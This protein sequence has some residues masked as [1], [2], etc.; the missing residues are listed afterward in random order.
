MIAIRDAGITG[1]DAVM[2]AVILI[3]VLSVANSSLFGSSRTLAA[4]ASQGQAPKILAYVDRTGRPIVAIGVASASG[5]LA[6]LSVSEVRGEAFKWLLA[7]SGLSSIFTWASICL[8]HVRFR[9]AWLAQNHTLDE[10]VY[11]SPTG[12][13][14]SWIGFLALIVVLV[15]QLW[16]ALDPVGT[17]AADAREAVENFF[18]AYLAAPIVLVFGIGYK[19]AYK[20]VWVR[21][22]TADLTSGRYA[23]DL[24]AMGPGMG[25]RKGEREEWPLWKRV[26]MT[27]C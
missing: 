3:S 1:L 16:V 25:D 11:R 17:P 12:I 10:L 21:S 7:L 8:A 9:S 4:L 15:T 26:Y 20:T 24:Q 5:L 23:H 27:M 18:S 6:F 14:G 2:N 22:H 19:L 13:I